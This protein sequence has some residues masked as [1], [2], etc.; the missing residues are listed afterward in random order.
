MHNRRL[1]LLLGPWL[2]ALLPRLP[3]QSSNTNRVSSSHVCLRVVPQDCFH[4]NGTF[5][6]RPW[7][8]DKATVTSSQSHEISIF[9]INT[10][11]AKQTSCSI[12]PKMSDWVHQQQSVY[13]GQASTALEVFLQLLQSPPGGF[14]IECR[15]NSPGLALFSSPGNYV[16]VL[17][18]LWR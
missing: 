8:V 4:S 7:T 9:I 10:L 1:L 5:L 2:E 14:L 15:F 18:H 6:L 17:Y 13:R 16:H 12:W 11:V 3:S